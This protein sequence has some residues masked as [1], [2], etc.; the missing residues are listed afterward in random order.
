[1]TAINLVLSVLEAPVVVQEGGRVTC[2]A[3]FSFKD[4]GNDCIAPVKLTAFGQMGEFLGQMQ[5]GERL[6]VSGRSEI[7]KHEPS[8][9]VKLKFL[10]V[11]A[12]LIIALD[13]GDEPGLNQ[14]TLVGRLGSD[15]E[16]KF[17]ESGAN[18]SRF[19]IAVNRTKT[20]TDWYDIA[21]WAK[22]GEIIG[23]YARKG[24]LIEVTGRLDYEQWT[25]KD[26]VIITKPLLNV[27]YFTFHGSGTG[28]REQSNGNHTENF[29]S[30]ANQSERE[31]YEAN[32][33]P[34]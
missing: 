10:S 18:V 22:P 4:R 30:T 34:F 14:W 7:V 33:V 3:G 27:R 5:V 16:V 21:G 28:R 17:F 24:T 29:S 1:M 23:E 32:T 6:L 8:E 9:G 19:A 15:P 20:V 11:I 25:N 26:G 12:D 2:R 13:E 31:L